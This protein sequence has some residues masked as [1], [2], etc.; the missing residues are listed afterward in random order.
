MKPKERIRTSN[1][2]ALCPTPGSS[3]GASV[4]MS[5]V[6]GGN[7]GEASSTEFDSPRGRIRDFSAIASPN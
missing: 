6:L 2:P 3:R 4:D 7:R 5:V 1:S